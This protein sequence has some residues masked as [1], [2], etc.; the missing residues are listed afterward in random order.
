M[1]FRGTVYAALGDSITHGYGLRDVHEAYPYLVAQDLGCS[2]VQNLGV[3]GTTLSTA[4]RPHAFVTRYEE[5]RLD[6]SLVTVLGGINDFESS[7]PLGT[8]QDTTTATV[9]GALEGLAQG[10]K[11]RHAPRGATIV[12]ITPLPMAAPWMRG[13]ENLA[14]YTV[15]AVAAAVKKTAARHSLPVLDLYRAFSEAGLVLAEALPD[16]QHPSC[17][18]QAWMAD[19]LERFLNDL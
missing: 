18:T 5:I 12:F 1:N 19:T 3:N 16:G 8:P 9:Y 4:S 11:A 6:A 10:L 7:D 15:A 14:G 13:T 2:I 17:T